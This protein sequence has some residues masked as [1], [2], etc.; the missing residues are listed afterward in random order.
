MMHLRNLHSI[1]EKLQIKF[2]V[3]KAEKPAVIF[4]IVPVYAFGEHNGFPFG[5]NPFFALNM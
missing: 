2:L 5:K 1:S 3:A 4:G